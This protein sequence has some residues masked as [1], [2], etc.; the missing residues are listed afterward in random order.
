MKMLPSATYLQSFYVHVHTTRENVAGHYYNV[1]N[2]RGTVDLPYSVHL[3]LLSSSFRA[4]VVPSCSNLTSCLVVVACLACPTNF[5]GASRAGSC[6][7]ILSASSACL[8]SAHLQSH[9]DPNRLVLWYSS[10]SNDCRHFACSSQRM[11]Q[12]ADCPDPKLKIL[13]KFSRC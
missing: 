6:G 11:Q 9:E 5:I 4:H 2:S 12:K 8:V 1:L 10:F 13:T 3:Y 7:A